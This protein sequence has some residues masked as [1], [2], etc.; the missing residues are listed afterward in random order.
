MTD[1]LKDILLRMTEHEF[2]TSRQLI[3]LVTILANKNIINWIDLDFIKNY[4][5]E[6]KNEQGDNIRN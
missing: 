3:N 1:D 2:K 4:E 5:G 6:D